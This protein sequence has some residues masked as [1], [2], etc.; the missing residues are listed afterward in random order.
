MAALEPVAHVISHPVGNHALTILR[1]KN[2]T[3][4]QFREA[5]GQV[6]PCVLYEASKLFESQPKKITTPICDTLGS[7][8]KNDVIIVPILRAGVAMVD[9]ALK[10]LPFARVGYF[11]LQRDEV[12]AT[13]ITDYQKH[14]PVQGAHVILLDPMLATGGSAEYALD[15]ISRLGPKTLSFCCIVAARDGVIRLNQKYPHVEIFT[16]AIDDHLNEKKF[17][18]PGL[19]DF[20]DRYHGTDV[21]EKGSIRLPI[22]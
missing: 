11:G 17:I 15:E 2:S 10:F 20:G 5:C 12:T 13:P 4:S 6:V 16:I 21:Q 9:T 7:E 3:L 19:G 22:K 18:V 1:D 14:P 8:L